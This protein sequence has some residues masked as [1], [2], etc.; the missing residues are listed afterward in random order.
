MAY[1]IRQ[2]KT[3]G[4]TI[5]LIVSQNGWFQTLTLDYHGGMLYP[6]LVRIDGVPDMLGENRRPACEIT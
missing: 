3:N 2:A 4:G 5:P 1:A 6:H